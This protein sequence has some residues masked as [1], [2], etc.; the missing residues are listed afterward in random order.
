[1]RALHGACERTE[2]GRLPMT[3]PE[4][5]LTTRWPTWFAAVGSACS[6]PGSDIPR[7]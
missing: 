2:T 5:R 3:T 6:W 7:T 1:M 4:R